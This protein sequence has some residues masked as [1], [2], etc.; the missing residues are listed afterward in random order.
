MKFKITVLKR[1]FNEE[2]AYK[3]CPPDKFGLCQIFKE[4]EEFI[5]EHFLQMPQGF[6]GWAWGDLHKILITFFRGGDFVLTKEEDKMV[7]CCTDGIRPV[8]FEIQKI[9]E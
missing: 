5:S 7:A 9:P 4:G 2:L 8:I 6:C 3:Y 1:T